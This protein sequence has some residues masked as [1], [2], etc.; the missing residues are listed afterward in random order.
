MWTPIN[1]LAHI[2]GEN[3]EPQPSPPPHQS[4]YSL[5]GDSQHSPQGYTVTPPPA[6]RLWTWTP[7]LQ[8]EPICKPSKIPVRKHAVVKTEAASQVATGNVKQENCTGT[9]LPSPVRPRNISC[10][11]CTETFVSQVGFHKHYLEDT[12]NTRGRWPSSPVNSV[13]KRTS[14]W[15]SCAST[16]SRSTAL[17]TTRTCVGTASKAFSGPHIWRNTV[18]N[19]ST[20]K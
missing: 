14:P 16:S 3:R 11:K 12:R 13:I 19:A 20:V 5:G 7:E 1:P 4:P 2:R 6:K 15:S 9:T 8:S 17:H 18:A 10:T